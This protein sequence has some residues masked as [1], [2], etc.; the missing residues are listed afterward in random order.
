MTRRGVLGLLI[1][2]SA[3]LPAL[4]PEPYT[5]DFDSWHEQHHKGV[6]AACHGDHPGWRCACTPVCRIC[7]RYYIGGVWFSPSVP[8]VGRGDLA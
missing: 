2:A 5:G 8:V 4:K 1:G 3:V 6:V 7:G